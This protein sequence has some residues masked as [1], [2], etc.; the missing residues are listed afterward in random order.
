MPSAL[1]MDTLKMRFHGSAFVFFPPFL[2]SCIL[3][4]HVLFIVLSIY[5]VVVYKTPL[6]VSLAPLNFVSNK[7]LNVLL[8]SYWGCNIS[9]FFPPVR[10]SFAHM[11]F[12][13]V[14][15]SDAANALFPMLSTSVHF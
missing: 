13:P 9:S 8:L 3:Y 14:A 4:A 11:N 12:F 7:N 10:F 2:S 5:D 15:A 1:Y 6:L